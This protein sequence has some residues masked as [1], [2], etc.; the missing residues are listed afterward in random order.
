MFG[1]SKPYPEMI[2]RVHKLKATYGV[3]IAVVSNEERELNAYRIRTFKLR[4]FVDSF[5]SS[6]LLRTI[7]A[8]TTMSLSSYPSSATACGCGKR[9]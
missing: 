8:G 6:C 1:K 9:D 7:M 3:K 2:K 4:G 5:I